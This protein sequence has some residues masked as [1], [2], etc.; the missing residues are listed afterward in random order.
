LLKITLF[1]IFQI[2]QQ[3]TY[4]PIRILALVFCRSI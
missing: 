3:K 4:T 1:Y 2:D